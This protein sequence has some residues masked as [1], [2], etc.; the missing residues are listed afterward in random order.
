MKYDLGTYSCPVTTSSAEAQGW[1]DQGLMWVYG[2]NHEEA[3]TCFEEAAKADAACA[4]AYWGIAYAIGPNYNRAWETYELDEKAEV[5]RRAHTALTQAQ[6]HVDV[7]SAP[8]R[9]LIE[10]LT[11]RYPNDPATEDYG[12]W[13]DAFADAMRGL[14]KVHPDNLEVCT[15]FAEA[16]MNR[17]PWELWDLKSGA[18][19]EGADTLE[20]VSVI[21]TALAEIEGGWDHAGLLHLYVH[22]MEMSPHPEKALRHGDRLRQLVPDAG[23]LLHMPTHIDVLCGEYQNVVDRNGEAIVAN[24]KYLA[25]RGADNFYSF[26]RAHDYHF[27][28]YGAMFLGQLTVAL[29]AADEMVETLPESIIRELADFLECYVS[30]KQHVHIRFGQWQEI[31]DTP[32]PEDAVLYC[33]TLAV[34]RYARA[35]A[36]ANLGRIAEAEEECEAFVKARAA[37]PESRAVITNT[38]A[39]VLGVAEEMM[40][41]E[42][43]YHKGEHEAAFEHLR[44]SVHL[45]DNL[46]YDEPWGWMQPARHALGALLLEQGQYEEAE[47]VYRAD[48][49]LDA[50]LSRA[51]QNPGNVWSLHGLYECLQQRGEKVEAPHIKQQLDRALARAE[52]PIKASCYCRKAAA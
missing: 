23:H 25:H 52:V 2:Y 44:K 39:E 27:R 15:I 33:Y 40:R 29:Q 26:Y 12:P 16:M 3:V 5:L 4:M 8:E 35:V 43:A 31:L 42:L 28:V 11:T 9:G 10:A 47:A 17:T 34:Q 20:I 19:A 51:C 14:H 1:F 18:A 21:E 30:V 48:L 13:D 50:T 46:A 22:T 36:F 45:D 6:E 7:L 32:L 41:G 38:A 24:R 37:V 49:G